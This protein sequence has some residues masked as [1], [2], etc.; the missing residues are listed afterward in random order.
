VSPRPAPPV[1]FRARAA[2]TSATSSRSSSAVQQAR[3]TASEAL[4][5]GASG[6]RV[7][8]STTADGR[9]AARARGI[10]IAALRAACPR[11]SCNRRATA[12][13]VQPA[14]TNGPSRSQGDEMTAKESSANEPS[15]RRSWLVRVP[16]LILALA[17]V[18]ALG[19]LAS[20]CGGSSGEGWPRSARP[21][22]RRPPAPTRRAARASPTPRPTRRACEA[23][24]YRTFP[25]PTRRA[26]FRT[27]TSSTLQRST[28]PGT[29]ANR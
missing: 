13:F 24:A 10:L 25:T 26:T 21:I 17:A 27:S 6:R 18:A 9:C 14:Q 2:A 28:P 5:A 22:R 20:A 16:L 12:P 7:R 8:R 15:G 3:A 1:W 4:P 11:G 29:P 23:M 19:L